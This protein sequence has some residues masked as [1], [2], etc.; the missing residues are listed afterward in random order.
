VIA[1]GPAVDLARYAERAL[2]RADYRRLCE[3]G[4]TDREALATA[5]D[6]TLLS[7]LSNDHRKVRVL[8]DAVERWRAA[9]PV[10]ASGPALPMYEA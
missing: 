8:R 9:R 7:L 5:N 4:M 6:E 2:D 10:P 3:A 1:L